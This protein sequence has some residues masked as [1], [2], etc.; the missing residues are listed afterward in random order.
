[1]NRQHLSEQTARIRRE[2]NRSPEDAAFFALASLTNDQR[3]K[4]VDR[5]NATFNRCTPSQ[6]LVY[7]V[8]D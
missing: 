2:E 3:Q 4:V 1:M 6:R 7:H 5:F 8:G